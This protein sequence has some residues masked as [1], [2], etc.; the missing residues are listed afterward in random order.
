[1]HEAK[2]SRLKCLAFGAL[3]LTLC[4]CES[5]VQPAKQEPP[6]AVAAAQTKPP[7]IADQVRPNWNIG[8]LAGSSYE[9]AVVTLRVLLQPDGTI[10]AITDVGDHPDTPCY[11]LLYASAKRAL[12][13]THRLQLPPGHHYEA[14]TFEFRP[15]DM[16]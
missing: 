14:I 5:P 7:S 12:L 3:L 10:T 2:G 15:S 1:M 11:R 9:N 16:Y 6:Q 8:G 4:A 13:R